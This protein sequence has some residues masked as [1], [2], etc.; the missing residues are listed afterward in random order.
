MKTR[1]VPVVCVMAA[2]LLGAVRPVAGT[3]AGA[4]GSRAISREGAFPIACTELPFAPFDPE[5]EFQPQ[6]AVDPRDPQ[7][8]AVV[9]TQGLFLSAVVGLSEDGGMSWRQVHVPIS[10]CSGGTGGWAA[11]PWIAWSPDGT[12]HLAAL[13]SPQA[14]LPGTRV[15]VTR[16]SDGGRT[17]APPVVVEDDGRS[18]DRESLAVDP[19]DPRRIYLSWTKTLDDG[20]FAVAVAASLDGGRSWSRSRLIHRAAGAR[21]PTGLSMVVL[22]DG[23]VLAAFE[24]LDPATDEATELVLRSADHGGTWTLV[25]VARTGGA[26]PRHPESRTEVIGNAAPTIDVAPDGT[27]VLAWQDI[28]LPN[29]GS[30][31]FARSVD[32]GLT[33]SREGDVRTGPGQVWGPTIAAGAK[34]TVAVTWYDTSADREDDGEWTAEVWAAHA[35]HGGLGQWTST[36]LAGPF[37][38]LDAF[39]SGPDGPVT[40]GNYFGLE[41]VGGGFAAAFSVPA[42]GDA[43]APQDIVFANLA[44]PGFAAKG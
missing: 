44:V 7:R 35:H 40:L 11:D 2:V 4:T 5:G 27:V 15:V 28:R 41:P 42:A 12:L 22:R 34:G 23:T 33:W 29:E 31:R 43:E 39:R 6:V 16:S 1:L 21:W 37:D 17:W 19:S 10:R 3:P 9:W 26:W 18:N 38:L 14:G 25:P 36:R 32:G 8:L 20:T 13:T 24:E 30:I